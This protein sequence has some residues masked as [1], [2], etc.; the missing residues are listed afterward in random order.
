MDACTRKCPHRG[1]GLSGWHGSN[2]RIGAEPQSMTRLKSNSGSKEEGSGPSIACSA[3]AL[4]TIS[5]TETMASSEYPRFSDLPL[6]KDGPHGNAWGLW[7]S[8]DQLGTLNLL[9]DD[10]IA[11]AATENILTGQR[12]SLKWVNR[13]T[14]S[15]LSLTKTLQLVHDWGLESPV[16]AQAT[17]ASHDQ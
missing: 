6:Q 10:V 5:Q 17:G 11:K 15:K 1:L 3:S 8:D 16:R 9:T 2:H 14:I 7:G 13:C 4:P 12:I